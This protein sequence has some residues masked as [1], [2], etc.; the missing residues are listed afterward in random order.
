MI[1]NLLTENNFELNLAL[2]Q[3]KCI[4]GFIGN[5]KPMLI[6]LVLTKSTP[7]AIAILITIPKYKPINCYN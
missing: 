3:L 6:N 4:D 1:K 5:A 2:M 7:S